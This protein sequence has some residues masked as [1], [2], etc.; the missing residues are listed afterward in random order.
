MTMTAH[1]GKIGKTNLDTVV[2]RRTCPPSKENRK[3]SSNSVLDCEN[4][5]YG[6]K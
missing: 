2:G 6:S 4:L 3:E 5:V 1:L